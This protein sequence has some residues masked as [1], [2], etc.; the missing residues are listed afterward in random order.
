M[1]HKKLLYANSTTV[2]LIAKLYK[3]RNFSD[4]YSS[5]C[6]PLCPLRLCV[7]KIKFDLGLA[8]LINPA[9]PFSD[10]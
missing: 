8:S 3:Q 6:A 2:E 5:L 1:G 7:K 10:I 4:F 9:T